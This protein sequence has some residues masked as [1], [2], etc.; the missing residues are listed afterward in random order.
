MPYELASAARAAGSAGTSSGG[1]IVVAS[2]GIPAASVKLSKPAGVCKVRNR[3]SGLVTTKACGSCRGRNATAPRS[4]RLATDM[5]AKLAVEHQE[6]LLISQMAVH[7]TAAPDAAP[8][9]VHNYLQTAE[10]RRSMTAGLRAALA[11]ADQPAMRKAI[12]GDFDLPQSD[13]DADLLAH[14]R[15][16]A[17][18]QYHRASTCAIGSV[19]DCDLAVLGLQGLRVADASVMP[20]VTRGNTN[21]PT[22][23]IAE[24]AADM[25]KAAQR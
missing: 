21:A 10:D 6:G 9:I 7:G 20:T 14:A 23:M 15:R 11:I 1:I 25:I 3:A 24:K 17:Q 22:I 19:V 5:D 16:T 4:T 12:T 13:S 8:R 18:T 2:A